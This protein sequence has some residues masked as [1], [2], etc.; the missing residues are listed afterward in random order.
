M[1]KII[2]GVLETC[3]LPDFNITD[4]QIR[5]D[6]GA[7]T[8]SLHVD[9]IKRER[10][11]GR[12]GVSFTLHPDIYDIDKVASCWAPISDVRQIKSSNGGVEQRLVIKTALM[13]HTVK[14]EIEITLTD[15][16]DM[17]YLMLLG[18]EGMGKDFL[19]DPSQTFL[20]SE[21]T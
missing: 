8:S 6:T 4:L 12:L 17:S 10:R 21:G 16:S 20:V 19:V 9:N 14:K 13:I 1:K 15:R 5:I 3:S 11:N 2:I 18:R 7:K